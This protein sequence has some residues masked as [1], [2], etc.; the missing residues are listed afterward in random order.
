MT[1]ELNKGRP[2]RFPYLLQAQKERVRQYFGTVDCSFPLK[3]I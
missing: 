3:Y 1:L 2:K